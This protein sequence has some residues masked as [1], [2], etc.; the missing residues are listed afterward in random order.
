VDGRVRL[1]RIILQSDIFKK[2]GTKQQKTGTNGSF[3]DAFLWTLSTIDGGGRNYYEESQITLF[4]STD[5][6]PDSLH[7]HGIVDT[8]IGVC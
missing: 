4:P 3:S 2:I 1:L 6:D 8:T 5:P 7:F